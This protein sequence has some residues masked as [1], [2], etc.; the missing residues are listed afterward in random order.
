MKKKIIKKKTK[1]KYKLIFGHGFFSIVIETENV[2]LEW[3]A[4]HLDPYETVFQYWKDT[5]EA[6][7]LL[8]RNRVT[9]H[10]Y[11]NRF[12]CLAS[13]RGADLVITTHLD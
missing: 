12:P 2:K 9:V 5:F 7:R 3:L 8:L 13:A 4:N 6:R 10:D 1:K 11:Y